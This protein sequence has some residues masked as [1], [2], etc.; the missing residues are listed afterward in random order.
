MVVVGLAFLTAAL[1]LYLWTVTDPITA[2]LILGLGYAGLGLILIFAPS[3][4][5]EGPTP[6]PPPDK[7]AQAEMPP[8]A[9]AFVQGMNQGIAVGAR[10]GTR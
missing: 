5:T 1:A 6:A 4:R 2:C 9:A 3:G 7:T 8:I 10:R